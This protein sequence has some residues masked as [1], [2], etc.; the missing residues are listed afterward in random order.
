MGH[1]K[2]SDPNKNV[3]QAHTMPMVLPRQKRKKKIPPASARLNAIG[4]GPHTSQAPMDTTSVAKTVL[5]GMAQADMMRGL[6]GVQT[7]AV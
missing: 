6:D 4:K 5:I 3:D 2:L 7:G 1:A